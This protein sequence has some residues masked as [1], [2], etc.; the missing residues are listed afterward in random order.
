MFENPILPKALS[1]NLRDAAWQLYVDVSPSSGSRCCRC[2][3]L[4]GDSHMFF[5]VDSV[6]IGDSLVGVRGACNRFNKESSGWCEKCFAKLV[7]AGGEMPEP[8]RPPC[9]VPTKEEISEYRK[10]QEEYMSRV[11]ERESSDNAAKEEL[12]W[13]ARSR[14][15]SLDEMTSLKKMGPNVFLR[16]R[17]GSSGIYKETDMENR[18]HQLLLHQFELRLAADKAGV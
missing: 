11:F 7:K 5:V 2:G 9:I 8:T 1:Q 14:V 16:F 6:K 12:L 15:L 10:K 17:G 18:F 13:S 4:Q 3:K